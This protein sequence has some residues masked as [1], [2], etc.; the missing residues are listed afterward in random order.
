MYFK[1]RER[2]R[3]HLEGKIHR[4]K[5]VESQN[6]SSNTLRRNQEEIEKKND[7]DSAV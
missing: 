2:Q 5:R 1:A 7:L 3:N 4:E 6:I